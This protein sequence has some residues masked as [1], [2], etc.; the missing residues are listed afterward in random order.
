MPE[1]HKSLSRFVALRFRLETI[2]ASVPT[3]GLKLELSR[4]IEP[5]VSSKNNVKQ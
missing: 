1:T 4:L 3:K 2:K 5:E